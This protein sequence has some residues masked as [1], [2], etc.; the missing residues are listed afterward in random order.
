MDLNQLSRLA[1]HSWR[2]EGHHFS[3]NRPIDDGGNFGDDFFE[4]PTALGN[5]G[6]IGSHSVNQSHLVGRANFIDISS[7]N[8]EFH[9]PAPMLRG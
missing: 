4:V 8:K 1:D 5:E 7:I 6:R 2:V 3:G 9:G